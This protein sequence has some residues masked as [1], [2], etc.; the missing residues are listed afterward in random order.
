MRKKVIFHNIVVTFQYVL[1]PQSTII[2]SYTNC[3]CGEE[4]V[5]N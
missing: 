2:I 1:K 3:M 5:Q 4:N